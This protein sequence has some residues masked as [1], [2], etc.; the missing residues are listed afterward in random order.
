MSKQR[1]PIVIAD[2]LDEHPAILAWSQLEVNLPRPQTIEVI[3]GI[4]TSKAQVFRLIGAGDNES[5]V[6]AKRT[7]KSIIDAEKYIY[8][9]ALTYLSKKSLHCYGHVESAGALPW[10]F[11]EDAGGSPFS[12]SNELHTSLAIDWLVELH[13]SVPK[14]NCLPD[15]GLEHYYSCFLSGHDSILLN[16]SNPALRNQDRKLLRSIISLYKM[17]LQKWD[18]L[19]ALYVQMPK[20]FIHGDFKARNLRVRS[21]SQENTLMVFDWAD[22]GWG[23]PGIDMWKVSLEDYWVRV[24]DHWRE[25]TFEKA[26]QLSEL[27]KLLW[28]FTAIDWEAK[29]LAC[30][31]LE[32]SMIRIRDY[33]ERL[34]S[35]IR[36]ISPLQRG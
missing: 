24:R 14:L 33:E 18:L 11:I 16:L 2:N 23:L 34:S 35:A 32:H 27:G 1:P 7:D 17:I 29:S 12:F 22:A 36:E 21:D 3:R 15:R 30:Q 5:S 4:N 9:E 28:C 10:I 31:E 13:T 8:D 19:N 26:A 20:C 25:L 6:I